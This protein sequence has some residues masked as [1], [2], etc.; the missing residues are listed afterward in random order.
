MRSAPFLSLLLCLGGVHPGLWAIDKNGVAPQAISLPSGPGSIQGLGESFQPQLNS[1]SGSTGLKLLLPRGPG[2]LTPELSLAYNS[3]GPNGPF[4]LGWS[5]TGMMSIRRNTDRGVP[6][7]TD[8][9]DGR[10]NDSDG[11]ID[12]PEELD[13]F[14][15]LGGE[16]LVPL[17]DGS[18]RAE[19][20]NA[21]FLYRRSGAGWE[22]RGKDGRRYLLGQNP[23]AR[24]EDSGR[25]FEWCLE[26]LRDPNGNTITYE[27]LTDPITPAQK[28]LRRVRWAAAVGGELSAQAY[29]AAVLTYEEG[30]PDVFTS[31]RSCFELK[32]RLRLRQL[33]VISHGLPAPAGALRGDLDGDSNATPDALV[34]RY[35]FEYQTGAHLSLLTRVTQLGFDG[36]TALPTL[37]YA[38]TAW[39]PPDDV[40]ALVIRSR[41]A[42]SAAFE[43][44]SVEL[45]DMNG[46]GLP[47]LLSTAGSQH[48]VSLN[49]GVDAEGRLAWAPSQPVAEAPSIDIS[50]DR[51]HLAD[52]TSDGLSDLMVKVSNTSFLCFDNTSENAWTANPIP[53]RNTDT[54]PI[55]P[56]DGASGAL[57]RSFD[58]DYSRSND[59][60]HTA[61]S[62][63]QLWLLL[64]GGRY[65]LEQ[66]LPPLTCDGQAFRFDLPGT[67]IAD[68][69]GDRL[70]DL[71]WIQAN[72]V[73]Y[74]PSRGRG[75][76]A[77]PV[78]LD[79]GRTLTAAEIE[80]AGFSDI[81]GDGLVDLTVVRPA[82]L[83]DGV[84]YWLNRFE[85]GLEGPRSVRGLPAQR[86]GDALRWADMNGNGT[87]DIVISL[88]QSA[89]GE[90]VIVIDLVPEGKNF[91]LRRADNGL[92]R[93]ISMDYESSTAQMVRA[94]AAGRPWATRMPVAV[95]VV[96]RI[97]EEDGLSPPYEQTISYRDPYYD[98]E[99]QEF[100]GFRA[101][102]A[103]EAG[104]A[105]AEAKVARFEF[106][107]GREEPCLK[108]KQLSAEVLGDGGKL[109]T[110]TLTTWRPRVLASGI[111]GRQVCF[112]FGEAED[113][114]VHEGEAAGIRIRSE[115]D[116]DDH[117]NAIAERRLGVLAEAGDEIVT[118]REFEIRLA[119]W[120]LDL[121]ARE[122]TRDGAGRLKAERRSFYDARGNLERLEQWLDAGDRF[123]PTLRQRFDAFGNVVEKTDARGSRRTIAYDALLHAWPVAETVHLA[124]RN[125]MMTAEYDL[126]LGVV[127]RAV[128]FS[129]ELT[130]YAYDPLGRLIEKQ[131]PG[132][133]HEAYEYQLG[134]P[135]SR[136]TKRRREDAAGNTL[137]ARVFYDGHGRELSTKLEA[138]DGQ[139]RVVSAKAFNSRK[140][141]ARK[142]L[143]YTS[144]RQDFE[145]PDPSLPHS[146]MTY[147]APGRLIETLAP[148]G[149]RARTEHRPLETLEHDGE[150]L[151]H[152]GSPDRRRSDG[153]ERLVEVEERNGQETY[154]TRYGWN[155]RGELESIT[156][157]LGN[158]KRFRFDSLGRLVEVDDPD[159]GLSRT[160]HDDVGNPLERT[161]ARG[162]VV[163]FTYDAANRP[164]TKVYRRGGPGGADLV[165]TRWHHDEPA[166]VLDF[167]DGTSGVAR[168]T[169]GRLAYGE[170]LSGE[171]HFSYDERG[172][173]EWVLK[174]VRDQASG[175]LVPYR[176]QRR[177][178]ILDRDV[179]IIFPDNDIL[180][181]DHGQGS[182]VTAIR[183]EG[184]QAKVILASAGYSAS[185]RP[186]RLVWGNGLE[187]R[188]EYDSSDRL[189]T[190]RL[191]AAGGA[192]LRHEELTY[193]L[194]SN[195]IAVDDLR[196]PAAV[197]GTSPRRTTARYAHD[198][199]H[200]LVRVSFAADGASG[201]ID[202]TLD[203]IGNLLSQ[204]T[205][206]RG[207]PGH[208]DDPAAQ[209]GAVSYQG[210]RQNRQGRRAGDPPGPHALTA[211]ASGHRFEYDASGNVTRYGAAQLSWDFEDRLE[212]YSAPGTVAEYVRDHAG[213]RA[214]RRV[215]RRGA[216]E[217]VWQVDAACEVR[218]EGSASTLVKYAFLDGRRVARIQGMLDPG[219]E[220]IQSLRLVAGWNL[221]AAAVET[222]LRLR[223]AFG[224]D[225]AV[226]EATGPA[227][228]APVDLSA[229]LTVG[230]ALWVHVPAARLAVLRG[231]PR[232]AV[233][234]A[235]SPG[236]L[237]AWPRL[238]AFRPREHLEGAPP[239]MVFDAAARR[240]LRRDASL[241]SFLSEAPA[242]LGSGQ[243]FWSPEAVRFQAEA[244]GSGSLVFYHQDAF[245]SV[246]AT[247]DATGALVEERA[248]YPFGGLRHV[249]RPGGSLAG[250]DYD[251]T[252]H[253]RDRESG[254][255]HMGARSYLDL[256][257]VFLSPDPRFAGAAALG[258]GSEED[259]RSFAA[260]L[261]NP[262]MGNLYAYAL[263]QP[264]KYLDP[265]GLEPQVNFTKAAAADPGFK[266]A[267]KSFAGTRAGQ[268]LL[269]GIKEA[270]G[271]VVIDVF[272]GRKGSPLVVTS[273]PTGKPAERT[274]S[275]AVKPQAPAREVQE[276]AIE[277]HSQLHRFATPL[278]QQH[279][280]AA[281]VTHEARMAGLNT[282]RAAGLLAVGD[283]G[284]DPLA[285]EAQRGLMQRR[286]ALM[287]HGDVSHAAFEKELKAPLQSVDRETK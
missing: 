195:V 135:V 252:G 172:N 50:S 48:R 102:E 222:T 260:F 234:A 208:L 103:R 101:A 245:G 154:R 236:P 15:G 206:P 203:A 283:G 63:I 196:P 129:G 67:H 227:S 4:G 180:R 151:A 226:Y 118:E 59:V 112:A 254:L 39:T 110:R 216:R 270:G 257:G 55:W 174:R 164:L 130:S 238:D 171:T 64:P 19:N 74:F 194:V 72:R 127:T 170:D 210:G 165:E 84:A 37:T 212:R 21:F 51:T 259:K 77:E 70:Q 68:L 256:A 133:A 80:R 167:G 282:R 181:F 158:V 28:Y 156:D 261:S 230:R 126:G 113:R 31:Y 134:A 71:V 262:Q 62:G 142:W 267:W 45:I 213:R 274:I 138:E 162:Q 121:L 26:E 272:R 148:D 176:T 205:P 207:Q 13:V 191:L 184:P 44:P 280:E 271:T 273:S 218:H 144:G 76:F 88:A 12:N 99:K 161:N 95:T 153:Q 241:P 94:Q 116:Y 38:Y 204:S 86:T 117:G 10:D 8:G 53:I 141:E 85:R 189:K 178:D 285:L 183:G 49:R 32:T 89:P 41:D 215:E 124:G 125:L 276:M 237:H 29:L 92:G 25:V 258:G 239:L 152:G 192:A 268:R 193:D 2:G 56:Y 197:P 264:L 177:Y 123:I 190:D 111:D 47:D 211:T 266:L 35:R 81:D 251:F 24:I 115:T 96:S 157:A 87:T 232:L 27:Y 169:A 235:P 146:S 66:R 43:S 114:F 277:I 136:V 265:D 155:A 36:T 269:S 246:A 214:V 200:R 217:Q 75:D 73:V 108:G 93:R 275:F 7:Y 179:A 98:P 128:S 60:L 97:R 78:V 287:F 91:L 119:E 247:T 253:E 166:G 185:G 263:R 168:N 150:D 57:S 52:A 58:A 228:Y 186:L 139:W 202:Y 90:K 132:G 30:R 220:T 120:R 249:H 219:R 173:V 42:P 240:W 3:G 149:G 175:L 199:L 65:S 11:R 16:E 242:E 69:N 143:P 104:D 255:V 109:F 209:L 17:Q 106:D 281:H 244:A 188:F 231:L 107:T 159:Q 100:R 233:P 163:A 105:S 9:P 187:S 46:D 14:S 279:Q 286:D 137:D 198:E 22:A 79:L 225:A 23:Q 33:D 248:H 229:P 201:I 1:G 250:A 140:L 82:F 160:L 54:W 224:A 20:E 182:F 5:L 18:F 34:R 131:T 147:D 284:A 223:D 278:I 122:V 83:S 40:A 6:Y 61:A 145:A 221:V 243:G